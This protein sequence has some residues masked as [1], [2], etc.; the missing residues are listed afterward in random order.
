[1]LNSASIDAVAQRVAEILREELPLENAQ[2]L[3]ATKTAALL[4]VSRDAV[5]ARA[6][7]LGA[8]RLGDG[9]KARLLFDKQRV[10]GAISCSESKGPSPAKTAASPRDRSKAQTERMGTKTEILPI[11][12][13]K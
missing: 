8:S 12:G 13:A 3:S 7:E 6:D 1:M 11:R 9:P 10:I 4:G 5:Y 2:Y